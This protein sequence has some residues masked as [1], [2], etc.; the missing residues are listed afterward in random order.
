MH[1]GGTDFQSDNLDKLM[2]LPGMLLLGLYM[3]LLAV[4]GIYVLLETWPSGGQAQSTELFWGLFNVPPG[5]DLRLILIAAVA[6]A[7]GSFI[8]IT[9]SFA[10][11]IG[12]RRL[13]RSWAIWYLA[14]PFIG[15]VLAVLFYLL[16]R[17]GLLAP[18]ASTGDMSPYG[19][20]GICGLVGMFSKQASDKLKEVFDHVFTSKGDEEREDKAK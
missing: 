18:T 20:A 5:L 8:H 7:L 11:Y 9:T 15:M 1:A 14:R 19:V 3:L 6:G 10:T 4:L 2:G 16:L 13:K 12:N 17:G